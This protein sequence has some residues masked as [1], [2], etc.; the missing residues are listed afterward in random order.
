[1]RIKSTNLLLATGVA[2]A[3]AFIPRASLAT[4]PSSP[5]TITNTPVPITNNDRPTAFN[6]SF[7]NLAVVPV[8]TG[9]RLVVQLVGFNTIDFAPT[10]HFPNILMADPTGTYLG[11]YLIPTQQVQNNGGISTGG[12]LATQLIVDSPNFLTV[13]DPFTPTGSYSTFY[14]S[15]YLLPLTGGASC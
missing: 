11:I 2:I 9:C 7:D 8:P 10:G 1:M 5:V 13:R 12:T 6:Q 14:I 4:P 3:S 15:G